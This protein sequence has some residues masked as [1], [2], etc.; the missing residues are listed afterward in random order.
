MCNS[1]ATL[2]YGTFV[3]AVS[4][5]LAGDAWTRAKPIVLALDMIASRRNSGSLQVEGG[6]FERVSAADI[7]VEVWEI[8]K[9]EVVDSET[10]RSKRKLDAPYFDGDC[11]D[12]PGSPCGFPMWAGKC[13]EG[14][15]DL[16]VQ[17]GGMPA[18]EASYAKTT[19]ALLLDFGFAERNL[20]LMSI[21]GDSWSDINSLLPL[22]LPLFGKTEKSVFTGVSFDADGYGTKSSYAC[23]DPSIF[24]L[25]S[26]AS[27]RFQRFVALF[28][29]KTF[30]PTSETVYATSTPA[31]AFS[32][33]FSEPQPTA[34]KPRLP[35]SS[36]SK[37]KPIKG[38]LK[39]AWHV[40]GTASPCY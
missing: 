12:T 37:L 29:L 16:F 1:S 7:P 39:L 15:W 18:L 27:C 20:P 10:R 23:L 33:A 11:D 38:K 36:A 17:L 13:C 19:K 30:D 21:H 40:G 2:F 26:S 35:R 25:P 31:A 22:S 8:V 5:F 4:L 24:S 34:N 3:K 9:H 32:A 14:C 6:A 28:R